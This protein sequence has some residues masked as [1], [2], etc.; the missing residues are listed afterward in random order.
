MFTQNISV[1]RQLSL[2]NVVLT[3][4][5]TAGETIAVEATA[6]VTITILDNTDQIVVEKTVGKVALTPDQVSAIA[7]FN[8]FQ[9]A[10][11]NRLEA[12]AKA[13]FRVQ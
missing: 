13:Q 8:N 3:V 11:F 6:D 12:A 1:K 5:Q 10:L 2:S 7:P 4:T 9:T